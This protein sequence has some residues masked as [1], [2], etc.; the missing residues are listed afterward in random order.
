MQKKVVITGG[1]GFLGTSLS[2]YLLQQ[3]YEVVSIDIMP[4]R[5]SRVKFVEADT[6]EGIPE[7]AYLEKPTYI[8]NLAGAAIFGRWSTAKKEEIYN[9]RINSTTNLVNFIRNPLYRPEALV[10]ASAIGIYGDS[11]TAHVDERSEVGEGFLARV[12][13]DW[14][15]AA[16]EAE[17]LGVRTTIIRNGH[18]LGAGGM[19]KKILPWTKVRIVPQLGP[20]YP[21]MSWIHEH[22]IVKLYVESMAEPMA[23]PV[24]NAVAPYISTNG[25]FNRELAKLTSA[26]IIDVP[27]SL[28]KIGLGDFVNEFSYGQCVKSEVIS[29]RFK[30]KYPTIQSALHEI[31]K[32]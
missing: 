14:E 5:S 25:E 7:H 29:G 13:A 26:V 21:C 20:G 30:F 9:S 6:I 16:R 2:W 22:D 32:R 4:P 24:I 27:L 28:A 8:I 23:P 3:N 10:S 15:T 31:V 18:I 1:S 12:A 17:K 19:M 11:G